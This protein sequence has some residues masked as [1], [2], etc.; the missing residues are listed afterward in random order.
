MMRV[1]PKSTNVNK[2][3]LLAF[4]SDRIGGDDVE[5]SHGRGQCACSCRFSCMKPCETNIQQILYSMLE[6][7]L[8]CQLEG[9]SASSCEV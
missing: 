3:V 2:H 7:I 8:R 6:F 9:L 4:G 1:F 5:I